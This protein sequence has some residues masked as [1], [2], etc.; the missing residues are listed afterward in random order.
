[1]LTVVEDEKL[2]Y[3]FEA[4]EVLEKTE[5]MGNM[6]NAFLSLLLYEFI[7]DSKVA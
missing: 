4:K 1:M 6:F 3:D 7:Y 5:S 2:V